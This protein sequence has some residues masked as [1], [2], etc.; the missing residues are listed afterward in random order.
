VDTVYSPEL[1]TELVLD[2]VRE[3]ESPAKSVAETIERSEHKTAIH[4]V[5]ASYCYFRDEHQWGDAAAQ[6]SKDCEWSFTGSLSQTVH[7]REEMLATSGAPLQRTDP[8]FGRGATRE[9]WDELKYKHLVAT[10]IIKLDRGNRTARVV[11]YCQVVA[12][13]G[14]GEK[15]ERGAHE[16]TYYIDFER[17]DGSGWLMK[18]MIT[19][20]DNAHN[21]LFNNRS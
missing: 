11:A 20:T 14:V 1:V 15:F 13:R 8:T 6:F 4:N 19:L 17:G 3:S 21:P 2:V 18:R 5:L 7:G 16:A 12:T 9:D 10:E